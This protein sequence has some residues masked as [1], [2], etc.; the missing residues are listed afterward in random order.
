ML[1]LWSWKIPKSEN[2]PKFQSHSLFLLEQCHVQGFATFA[3][4]LHLQNP[5]SK[6]FQTV[7][8]GFA[9]ATIIDAGWGTRSLLYGT[10][11]NT[12][13][14]VFVTLQYTINF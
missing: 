7:S 14:K 3:N 13:K 8:L 4:V 5:L 1:K 6:L 12:K 9:R 10:Q 2:M 11:S